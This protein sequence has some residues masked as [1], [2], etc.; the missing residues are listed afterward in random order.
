MGSQDQRVMGS[1]EGKQD[2]LPDFLSSTPPTSKVKT[3]HP[4]AVASEAAGRR[5]KEKGH[6]REMERRY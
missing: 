3:T 5:G 6:K 4:K 1:G 2:L